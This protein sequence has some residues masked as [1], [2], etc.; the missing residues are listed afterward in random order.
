MSDVLTGIGNR[1][2]FEQNAAIALRQ[3]AREG[4]GAVLAILD[5]DHFKTFND[6]YGHHAGDLALQRVGQTLKSCLRRPADVVARL[7]GEEF[8][9]LLYGAG[10]EQAQALL[11][12]MVRSIADLTI[13]HEASETAHHLTVSVGAACF[14]GRESLESLYRRADAALYASKDAGRNRAEFDWRRRPL[15]GAAPRAQSQRPG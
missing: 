9:L 11:E 3:A 1:R 5:V 6:C 15:A 7:G 4:S 8:G 10:P 2:F 13:P 12:G 14:D